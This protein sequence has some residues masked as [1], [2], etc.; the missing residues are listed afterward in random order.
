MERL[1]R[2]A[3]RAILEAIDGM[4][5]VTQNKSFEDYSSDWLLRHGVQRGIEIISEAVRRIPAELQK[6]QPHIPTSLGRK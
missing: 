1:V 4:E 6:T 5:G 3:L 2:P